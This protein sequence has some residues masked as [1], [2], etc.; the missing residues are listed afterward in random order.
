M[1]LC[2]LLTKRIVYA[3]KGNRG[4]QSTFWIM[5]KWGSMF[6]IIVI[7]LDL[8]TI[9]WSKKT[10]ACTFS[11]S[12]SRLKHESLL[13]FAKTWP[14]IK[15]VRKPECALLVRLPT[16]LPHGQTG[17][18]SSLGA[19]GPA[20]RCLSTVPFL[21]DSTGAANGC[22][23]ETDHPSRALSFPGQTVSLLWSSFQTPKS[24]QCGLSSSFS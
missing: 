22:F 18:G 4:H 2:Y 17:S 3:H 13:V 24:P 16:P 10:T 20:V 9:P 14:R 8:R 15:H 7:Q 21:C 11:G 12:A 1:S 6:R 19:G 5:K 23:V